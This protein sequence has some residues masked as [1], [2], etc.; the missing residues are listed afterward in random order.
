MSVNLIRY[1][2]VLI[3]SSLLVLGIAQVIFVAF[4][5]DLPEGLS[6]IL[7]VVMA[8]QV[9]G[10]RVARTRGEMITKRDAW[11]SALAMT[12]CV[13]AL[14]FAFLAVFSALLEGVTLWQMISPTLIVIAGG[15]LSLMAL[16]ANRFM[17]TAGIK[18]ELRAI[19]ARKK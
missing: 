18:G 5:F 10:Q 17:L 7:P 6:T 9:E 3:I 15:G 2:F 11:L 13:I 12:G 1:C 8:A 4:G 16:F 19:A 14:N